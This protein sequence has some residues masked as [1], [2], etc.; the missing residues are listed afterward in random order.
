MQVS[1]MLENNTKETCNF[2]CGCLLVGVWSEPEL[3]SNW[4][5]SFAKKHVFLVVPQLVNKLADKKI[6]SSANDIFMN[7]A[8]AVGPKFTIDQIAAAV[9]SVKSPV[10]QGAAV[11]WVAE[12]VKEFGLGSL[13]V[14]VL[15]MIPDLM[16]NNFF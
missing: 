13:N 10:A 16:G 11:K 4:Y 1:S 2:P 6:A 3:K 7:F 14:Q 8:E 9:K 12:C 15:R 5:R